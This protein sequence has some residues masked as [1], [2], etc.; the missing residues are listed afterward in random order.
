MTAVSKK[1]VTL[2]D[3]EESID[4]VTVLGDYHMNGGYDWMAVAVPAKREVL[5]LV[6]RIQEA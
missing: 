2:A 3:T 1:T 6:G 5:K 4:G